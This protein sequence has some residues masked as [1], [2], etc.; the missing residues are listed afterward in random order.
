LFAATRS[1]LSLQALC[2]A[3]WFQREYIASNGKSPYDDQRKPPM[4]TFIA[5]FVQ[6]NFE[7]CDYDGED[8][9]VVEADDIDAAWSHCKLLEPGI[10]EGNKWSASA[11]LLMVRSL[12][13]WERPM[14]RKY[15][16]VQAP[17][18]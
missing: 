18:R 16:L 4:A 5:K 10:V 3:L 11:G 15:K 6:P 8:H 9:Y 7:T 13:N 14:V 17:Y 12:K 1:D 2:I